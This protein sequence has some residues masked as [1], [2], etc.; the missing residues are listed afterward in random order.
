MKNASK[1]V[2]WVTSF[3]CFFRAVLVSVTINAGKAAEPASNEDAKTEE[4]AKETQNPVVNL[5]SVPFQNNFN[6]GIGPND[7]TQWVLN[8]QPVIPI[9]LNKD[10]NLITRTIMPIINQPSPAPGIPS[11]FGLGD[12]LALFLCALAVAGAIEMTQELNTPFR[13]IIRISS[14]P[15]KTPS[16][17]SAL[18]KAAHAP[19][20]PSLG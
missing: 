10:W 13:G 5:I 1:K 2:S 18:N 8:V 7:A 9:S 6:F 20:V 12:I 11:A 14:K 4:L 15:M 3:S 19:D 16:S 17:K